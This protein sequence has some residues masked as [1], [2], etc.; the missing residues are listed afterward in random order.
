MIRRPPRSTRTD[1]LFPYTTLFRSGYKGPGKAPP[2]GGYDDYDNFREIG[3]AGAWAQ[4]SGYDQL[5]FW[6]RTSE[7]AAYDEY[8]QG[9]ALA[10]LLAANPSNVPTIWE[11]GLW[12]PE[13][14]SGAL[15]DW[16]EIQA[17]S[18]M[19]NNHLVHWP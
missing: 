6:Q 18:P 4:K 5:P 10:T 1:T 3:S 2:S 17:A 19:R 7:H 13:D 8:W 16:E 14:L 15:T 11:T 9:Q 12:D